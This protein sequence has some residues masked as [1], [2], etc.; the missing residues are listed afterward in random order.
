MNE[1]ELAALYAVCFP[2]DAKPWSATSFAEFERDKFS[3]IYQDEDAALL[4]RTLFDEAEILTLFVHPDARQNGRAQDLLNMFFQNCETHGVRQIHLEV[5][6]DNNAAI[7]LYRK[8]G[9]TNHA[10]RKSYY[11]RKNGLVV[12][13]VVMVK[14]L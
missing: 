9:F 2:N 8:N 14:E 7:G 6:K 12:D 10:L 11:R 13:A 3:T 5:A 1:R 4:T